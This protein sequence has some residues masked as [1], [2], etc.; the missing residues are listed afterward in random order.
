MELVTQKVG[1]VVVLGLAEPGNLDSSNVAS[2]TIGTLHKNRY[3][4]P[5]L[6]AA[7]GEVSL[8]PVVA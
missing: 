1:G 2:L 8:V 6:Y 4:V 7:G 5:E 3:W